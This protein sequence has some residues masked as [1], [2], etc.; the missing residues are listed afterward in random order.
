MDLGFHDFA[1][2]G[3]VHLTGGASGL[4][5]TILIG[6][7]IGRF[8]RGETKSYLPHNIVIIPTNSF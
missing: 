5:L 7:R 1:G 6:A 8:D 3:I 4:V 2:S